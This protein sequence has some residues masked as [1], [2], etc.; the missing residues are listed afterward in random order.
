VKGFR[1]SNLVGFSL[2]FGLVFALVYHLLVFLFELIYAH[3][4]PLLLR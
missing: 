1:N 2:A 3:L 4:M